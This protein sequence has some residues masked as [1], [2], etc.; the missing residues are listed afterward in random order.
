MSRG[1]D[2]PVYRSITPAKNNTYNLGSS[3]YKWGNVYATTFTGSFSGNATSATSATN[4][5]SGNKIVDTY[6]KKTGDTMTGNL[7]IKNVGTGANTWASRTSNPSLI[8]QANDGQSAGFIYTQYDSVQAPD[9]V[10]LVGAQAGT[11]F[12]ASNIKATI[13]FYG[14]L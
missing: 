1:I 6:V 8:F 13:K 11:Y 7:I 2:D 4:D 3:S 5:S 9:S 12:I 14:D 10:T